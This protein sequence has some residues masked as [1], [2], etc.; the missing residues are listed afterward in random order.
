[1][2]HVRLCQDVAASL[3]REFSSFHELTAGWCRNFSGRFTVL[4]G[5][6]YRVTLRCLGRNRTC[7]RSFSTGGGGDGSG[8]A[9]L[10]RRS[11]LGRM[12]ALAAGLVGRVAVRILDAVARVCDASTFVMAVDVLVLVLHCLAVRFEGAWRL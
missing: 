6:E 3:S 2:A 1:L 9:P 7:L 5:D 4:L 8:D 11:V 12:A 10:R